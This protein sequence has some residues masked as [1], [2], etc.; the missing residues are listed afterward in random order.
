MVKVSMF[1]VTWTP[2]N[3]DVADTEPAESNLVR[4]PIL[5]SDEISFLTVSHEAVR[6]PPQMQFSQSYKVREWLAHIQG[7]PDVQ[8]ARV[9]WALVF[10]A[11]YWAPQPDE[12]QLP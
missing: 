3:A 1:A 6:A 8:P 4:E 11:I 12:S 10:S 5:P 2:N 7:G 9:T